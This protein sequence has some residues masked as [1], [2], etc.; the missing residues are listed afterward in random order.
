MQVQEPNRGP[1]EVAPTA[2]NTLVVEPDIGT[3]IELVRKATRLFRDTGRKTAKSVL[4]V[5]ESWAAR[6]AAHTG[7]SWDDL[8]ARTEGKLHGIS[9]IV[10][11]DVQ[12]AT[13]VLPDGKAYP[14][15]AFRGASAA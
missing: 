2:H 15:V 13:Y 3:Q 12:R 8:M 14:L 10:R 9:V 1:K 7:I 6:A 5:S 4:I 11:P